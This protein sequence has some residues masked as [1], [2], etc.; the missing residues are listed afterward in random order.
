MNPFEKYQNYIL[1][2][3]DTSEFTEEDR[4][5]YHPYNKII[6]R[7]VDAH[8]DEQST[9]KELSKARNNCKE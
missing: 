4:S 5:K 6:H 8:Q 2:L 9:K 1:A 7:R 3:Q